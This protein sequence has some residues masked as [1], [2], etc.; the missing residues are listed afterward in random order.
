MRGRLRSR[1]RD[2]IVDEVRKL[3]R[4]GVQEIILAGQDT[5]SYGKD[6][7]GIRLSGLLQHLST[8]TDIPW[9]RVCY[10]SIDN[11]DDSLADVIAEHTNIC[12]YLDIPIQHASPKILRLMGRCDRPEENQAK[13]D[14]LRQTVPEIA[15]RTSVI[16]GFPGETEKDFEELVN[17]LKRSQ[18]DMVGVFAFSPQPGTPASTMSNQVPDYIKQERLIEIVAIQEEISRIRASELLGKLTDLLVDE[19]HPDYFIG[20][21]QYDAPE[22]DRVVRVKGSG[23]PGKFVK[24]R[25][26]TF[27]RHYEFEGTA[28][29]SR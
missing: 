18:F 14:H 10:A 28:I 17:F 15:L 29:A 25:I 5:A 3:A 27:L 9:I 19:S 26:E 13:I 6:I 4:Q 22:V 24:V 16:V 7:G 12:K 20:H 8:H 23:D 2:E 21:T 11:V 1:H